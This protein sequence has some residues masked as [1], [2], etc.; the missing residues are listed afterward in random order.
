MSILRQKP[1]KSGLNGADAVQTLQVPVKPVGPVVIRNM[2]DVRYVYQ[3]ETK[4]YEFPPAGTLLVDRRDVP[5]LLAK[6]S[7]GGGCCGYSDPGGSQL[8]MEV[9]Q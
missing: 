8:F 9:R 3:G 6:L 2:R 1:T 4:R 5:E 7:R